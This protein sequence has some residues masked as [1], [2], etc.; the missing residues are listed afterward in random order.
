MTTQPYHRWRMGILGLWIAVGVLVFVALA[1]LVA[2]AVL[3]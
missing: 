1:W 3:D 2:R